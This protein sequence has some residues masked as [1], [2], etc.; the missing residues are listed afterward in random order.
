MSGDLLHG[1]ALGAMR[2]AF[3]AAPEPWIDLSTGINPWPYSVDAIEPEDW[4]R[5]PTDKARARCVG[6]MAGAFGAEAAA[7]LPVPGSELAI[8][9]LPLVLPSATLAIVSPTYG[10]HAR[11]WAAAG[12]LVRAVP[13]LD[14]ALAA[15]ADAIVLC[16]PNN[17]DGRVVSPD[18]VFAA[19]E[20][21]AARSGWLIVDEAFAEVEPYLSVAAHAGRTGL[22]VLRSF[23]KFYGLAGL[24]LAAVLGP[25]GI[26]GEMR[27]LVGQWGVSGPALRLGATAYSD[28]RWRRTTA[29]RL[30]HA[31]GSLDAIVVGGGLTIVGGTSLFRF[32]HA[33]DAHARWATL[34]GAGVYVRRFVDLPHH[35]RIGLP[36]DDAGSMR[37]AAALAR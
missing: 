21:Q 9:L 5:L 10:D 27:S 29:D 12:R 26:L 30:A 36:V 11:A 8:R 4:S 1:G 25:P 13:T 37:L 19:A 34:A 18:T 22:I 31:A 35:L 16:N 28:D 32:V 15:G 17:P 2:A 3:P 6:A 7:I 20:A 33:P 24:R 23:G 14:A